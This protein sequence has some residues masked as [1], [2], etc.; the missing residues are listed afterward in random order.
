[1]ARLWCWLF[2][3][4][5]VYRF[6]FTSSTPEFPCGGLLISCVRCEK[7]CQVK[8]PRVMEVRDG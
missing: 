8:Y 5:F 7:V 2:G 1:M 4:N 3:H 6:S